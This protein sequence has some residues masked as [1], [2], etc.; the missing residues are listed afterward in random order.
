MTT[1]QPSP[2][3]RRLAALTA[4]VTAAHLLVLQASPAS[5]GLKLTPDT[6][7]NKAF[8]TRRIEA[9]PEA[10]AIAARPEKPSVAAQTLQKAAAN[11]KIQPNQSVAQENRVSPAIDS[12]AD[13]V[14]TPA[15]ESPVAS[16]PADVSVTFAPP[17][18]NPASQPVSAAAAAPTAITARAEL[19]KPTLVTA[20]N[21]PG[22]ARLQYKMTGTSKGLTYYANA[23][24]NWS[25][26]GSQ[27]EAAMKVSA[28]F[29][30]SRSMSSVGQITPSGLAPTRFADKSRSE[31]AVHF[32]ADKG[33]I[34]FSANTPDAPWI[35]GAQDRVSVFMQLAGMLAAGPTAANG[36]SGSGGST[37][38]S[39]FPVGSSIT[40]Y[41]LGPREA[42]TWTFVV[43]ADE[44]LQLPYGELGTLKLS[45]KPRREYD[46]KVEIWYAPSLGYLPVRNRI[47]QQNGDF[48]DQV[49]TDL[50]KP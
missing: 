43:E 50:G 48:I 28:M 16:V 30:G 34:T 6:A 37:G 3:W 2:M 40:V 17:A 47:T 27:Y 14:T 7:G 22:S 41:T 31:L 21:L 38:S 44:K 29:V 39:G 24:L 4:L 9:P 13:P 35:E 23:E 42:D 36:T 19:P 46:Q 20:V 10:V 33:K 49:L 12:I 45:R 5:M 8:A 1:A 26:S 11:P 18:A 25:N 32:D 15:A